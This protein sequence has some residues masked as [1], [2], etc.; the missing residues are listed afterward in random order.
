MVRF[1]N[2]YK[3]TEINVTIIFYIFYFYCIDEIYFTIF[4]IIC[5]PVAYS[6]T[7][8]RLYLKKCLIKKFEI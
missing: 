3:L 4:I 6:T 1:V 2:R 5:F 8:L 7:R